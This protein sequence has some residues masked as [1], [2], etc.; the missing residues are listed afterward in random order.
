VRSHTGGRGI[1]TLANDLLGFVDDQKGLGVNR[2]HHIFH[3]RQ[4]KKGNHAIDDFQ[5]RLG[6]S[7]PTGK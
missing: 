2:G 7:S 6:V 3:L 4:L 5:G 1:K